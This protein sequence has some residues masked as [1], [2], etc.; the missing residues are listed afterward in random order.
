[1]QLGGSETDRGG[2]SEAEGDEG[3]LVT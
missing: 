2:L 3:S 1:V